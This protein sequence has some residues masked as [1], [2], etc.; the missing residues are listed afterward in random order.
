MLAAFLASAGP[1][2]AKSFLLPSANVRVAVQPD[3][4]LAI[5]EEISFVYDGQFSGG[6]REIPLR[7]GEE[8]TDVFVEEGGTRFS[9]GAPTEIG[10][11]GQ[12][13]TFGVARLDG[14]ARIVWHYRAFS[15]LRTFTIG[16]TLRGVAVAYDDVVDVNLKVWGDEWD[17]PLANL[18]AELTL[19]GP[20]SGRAYRAWGHPVS[21]RG[22][23]QRLPDH[24][25]LYANRISSHQFV[26]LR[27]VFPASL[28]TSPASAKRERGAA[29]D[30]IVAEEQEDAAAFERDQERI[31]GALRNLPLT[32]FVLLLAA[33]GPAAAVVAGT[34][35]FFGRERRTGYDREYEQEPPSE[36]APALVPPLLRQRP[37]VG[38]H[39][40]TATLFDPYST[41]AI[42]GEAGHDRAFPLCGTAQA[43]RRGSR[44]LGRRPRARARG[45][46]TA[47]GEGR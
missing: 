14:G 6:F 15:E 16:Y 36:L 20:T 39:E 37:A 2:A 33:L 7:Q 27:V 45:P 32:V 43:A 9:P 35:W 30:R 47:R 41:G 19:P 42:R 23:V 13:G 11:V 5:E 44:A 25:L 17:V 26:E 34:Y 22:E 40:F 24:V 8:I 38:S 10:S 29:L 4:A 18:T 12:E 3:G 46:R 28:L 1:A 31:R 21:V